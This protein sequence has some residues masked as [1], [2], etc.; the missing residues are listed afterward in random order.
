[1][2]YAQVLWEKFSM[3]YPDTSPIDSRT[4]LMI[5]TM[6]AQAESNIV[7]DN[8]DVLVKIGLGPRAKDDL[9]FARDTCRMLL[10]IKQ[11]NKDIEK[12]SLR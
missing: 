4:A 5:I 8:L 1:M 2:L 10:K 9:L 12:S 3:K 11:N 7:I 6:I